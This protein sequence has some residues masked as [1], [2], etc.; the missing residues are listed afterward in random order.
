MHFR[1]LQVPALGSPRDI[2]Y[3]NYLV[4]EAKLEAKKN[5]LL[6]L[7]ALGTPTMLDDAGRRSW[8]TQVKE[9]FSGLVALLLGHE[10]AP[11]NNDVEIIK[12]FYDKVVKHTSPVLSKSAD[13]KLTVKGIPKLD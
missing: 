8:D 5:E 6:L 11:K 13:G 12:N 9:V 10:T 2:V 1:G 3:R 4:H 7:I